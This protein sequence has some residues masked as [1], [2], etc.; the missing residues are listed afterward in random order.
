MVC[1]TDQTGVIDPATPGTR[2]WLVAAKGELGRSTALAHAVLDQPDVPVEAAAGAHLALAIVAREQD[3]LTD[4][5]REVGAAI[6]TAEQAGAPTTAAVARLE[7]AL[8]ATSEGAHLEAIGTVVDVDRRVGPPGSDPVLRAVVD[9]VDAMVHLAAGDADRAEVLVDR[10][11]AGT[12]RSLLGARIALARGREDVALAVAERV[13]GDEDLD[14]RGRIEALT[15]ASRA[16]SELG[17]HQ[18]ARRRRAELVALTAPDGH[19]R[20]YLDLGVDPPG[21]DPAEAHDTPAWLVLST[22]E[23]QVLRLLRG[24]LDNRE[25]GDALYI[26]VNTVKTHLQSIYRKLGVASRREA[27]ERATDLGLL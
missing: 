15:L 27:V 25:I 23:R 19:V 9:A 24:R 22:R 16:E 7:Q 4:A 18:A 6:R 12:A 21:T 11:P 8:L 20:A 13:L 5:R 2:A 17:A 1:A 14:L 10:L 3:R 26:S